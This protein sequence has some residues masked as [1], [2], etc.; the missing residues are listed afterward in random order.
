M[1]LAAD[2]KLRFDTQAELDK[3]S[4]SMGLGDYC[5]QQRLLDEKIESERPSY[6]EELTKGI[7]ED[8][9]V[10]ESVPTFRND[11]LVT[12]VEDI[13]ALLQDDTVHHTVELEDDGPFQIIANNGSEKTHTYNICSGDKFQMTPAPTKGWLR[14]GH[15]NKPFEHIEI[16]LTKKHVF[17]FET[18]KPKPKAEFSVKYNTEAYEKFKEKFGSSKPH[19][20]DESRRSYSNELVAKSLK[21]NWEPP[22]YNGSGV[23]DHPKATGFHNFENYTGPN[24]SGVMPKYEFKKYDVSNYLTPLGVDKTGMI[25]FGSI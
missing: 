18:V 25:I 24:V 22:V 21:W 12:V 3:A 23:I 13:S 11:S 6:E 4:S 1:G 8:R 5:T 20:D 19:V 9:K 7:P 16:D 14:V 2:V 15:K 10:K 17:K